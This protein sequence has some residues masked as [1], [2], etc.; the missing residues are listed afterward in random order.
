[1]PR[2]SVFPSVKIEPKY[3][4]FSDAAIVRSHFTI[5]LREAYLCAFS[6]ACSG[7][8]RVHAGHF[9]IYRKF[10]IIGCHVTVGTPRERSVNYLEL[11]AGFSF[12]LLTPSLS[13]L[14]IFPTRSQFRS[15]A[16]FYV[17]KRLLRRLVNL[18][19]FGI[20]LTSPSFSEN[21]K[22]KCS[23]KKTFNAF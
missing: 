3:L 5:F 6:F 15:L 4:H 11:N 14:L 23:V 18:S 17:L 1:M 2:S 19:R 9:L 8:Y 16:C 22:L 20:Y 13:L 7:L 10:I 21:A 12:A